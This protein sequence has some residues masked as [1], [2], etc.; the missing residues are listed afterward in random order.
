MEWSKEDE[1]I[2][3]QIVI[4]IAFLGGGMEILSTVGSWRDSLPRAEIIAM[5]DSWLLDKHLETIKLLQC[6]KVSGS[7][8]NL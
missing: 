7:S 5:L 6:Y 3:H 1:I 4:A 8:V 2:K